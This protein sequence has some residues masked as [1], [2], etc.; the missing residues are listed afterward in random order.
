MTDT[1]KNEQGR[2]LLIRRQEQVLTLLYAGNRLLLANAASMADTVLENI[3]IAK[4]KSIAQNIQAAFV[5]YAPGK[6]GFLPLKECK[7]PIVTNRSYDGRLVA[8][9]EIVIQITAESQKTKEANAD[10]N[11]SFAGRYLVLSLEK[12]QIG[13]SSRLSEEKKKALKEWMADSSEFADAGKAYSVIFRTNVEALT[14]YAALEAELRSLKGEA[15]QVLKIAENRTCFS[16][17]KKALPPYLKA[18]QDL[19]TDT[20]EK[21]ITDDETLYEEAKEYLMQHQAADLNKLCFYEDALLPLSKLYSVESRLAEALDRK[22]WMRSG[23]YLVIDRA[24]ALT[25]IDVNTGKFSGKKS[26]SETFFQIN[27]EAAEEIGHQLRLRNLSGIIIIDFINMDQG[28]QKKALLRHLREVLSADPV[29]TVVVDMTP[30]GLVEVTRK[31]EKRSLWEQ[32][33]TGVSK[34]G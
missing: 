16:C 13:Y 19:Y 8:G 20:Y 33:Q 5:E 28:A 21:I 30:L 3:Y 25:C 24:E 4:V 15:E 22:V 27:M 14:E 29:K 10:T 1:K 12:K 34:Q 18:L 31:K 17:L 9:D 2:V 26:R 32:L 23:A 11:L 7:A 6:L